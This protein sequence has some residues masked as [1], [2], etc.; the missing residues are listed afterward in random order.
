[1]KNQGVTIQKAASVIAQAESLL[2]C[3]GAGMGVDSGLPDFR[4]NQGFWEAYP[5][6]AKLRMSFID[7]ANPHWFDSDPHTAWGFY[8]HRLNMYR[9]TAPHS[10]FEILLNWGQKKTGGYFVFTSNVD[11]HFQKS[12]FEPDKI[13]ECHGSIHHLQCSRS[14]S[15]KIWDGNKCR[16]DVD[17]KNMKASDPLPKCP[18]CG[19]IARPNI[20][21]FGDWGWLSSRTA[22]Q[23]ELFGEWLR[24]NKNKKIAI[25]ECGAGTGVPT[26]RWT[27][28]SVLSK[29]NATLIRINIREPEAPSGSISIPR[30]AQEVL[31]R[32]TLLINKV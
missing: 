8:G 18:H 6:F 25:I 21:M 3:A 15:N 32:I 31:E 23:E 2:I 7:M 19:G 9:S 20:L 30:G 17:E 4:G 10:G 28:E 14:C 27:S 1:M 29:Y 26:V 24:Q 22:K 16:I 5:P 11:G 13:I 12:D